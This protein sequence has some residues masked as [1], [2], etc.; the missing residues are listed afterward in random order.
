MHQA[1]FNGHKEVEEILLGNGA[2]VNV[3]TKAISDE[4][5]E[6]ISSNTEKGIRNEMQSVVI[7]LVMP[8]C[9]D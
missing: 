3:T 6:L 8:D 1:V 5:R 9:I 4:W 2:D 7:A